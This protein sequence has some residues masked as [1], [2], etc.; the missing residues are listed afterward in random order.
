MRGRNEGTEEKKVV[1][2]VPSPV[3]RR[4]GLVNIPSTSQE[5]AL[6]ISNLFYDSIALIDELEMNQR[7]L[8]EADRLIDVGTK[9]LEECRAQ[10]RLAYQ[11]IASREKE[12][13]GGEREGEEREEEIQ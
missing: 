2:P 4:E 3:P 1:L 6:L 11:N 13:M 8:L 12:L 10:L 9:R 5:Q 7:R